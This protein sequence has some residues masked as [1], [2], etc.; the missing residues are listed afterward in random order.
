MLRRKTLI[1]LRQQ[2]SRADLNSERIDSVNRNYP[3]TEMNEV[4]MERTG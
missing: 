4:R 2:G 3:T 1:L